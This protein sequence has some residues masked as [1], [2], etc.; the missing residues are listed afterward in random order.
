MPI[1]EFECLGCK[2]RFEEMQRI[3]DSTIPVCPRCSSRRVQRRVSQ[4]SFI[5]KGSGW[6]ATDYARKGSSSAVSPPSPG[7]GTPDKASGSD[8][9]KGGTSDGSSDKKPDS[10]SGSSAKAA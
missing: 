5:L 2:T 8:G 10:T 1:R 9:S 6:Y 7:P 3:T 4:T